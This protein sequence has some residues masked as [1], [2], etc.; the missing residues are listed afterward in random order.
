LTEGAGCHNAQQWKEPVRGRDKDWH[1]TSYREALNRPRFAQK[2]TSM[3]QESRQKAHERHPYH[4]FRAPAKAAGDGSGSRNQENPPIR[5]YIFER[6]GNVPPANRKANRQKKRLQWRDNTLMNQEVLWR[7]GVSVGGDY[8]ILSAWGNGISGRIYGE[9]LHISRFVVLELYIPATCWRTSIK[10]TMGDFE[11]LF[12]SPSLEGFLIGGRKDV[13]IN[14]L[15][16]MLILDKHGPT[17]SVDVEEGDHLPTTEITSDDDQDK[18]STAT[19][20]GDGSEAGNDSE[21][22]TEPDTL[23]MSPRQCD[24]L[25]I[26]EQRRQGLVEKLR[27]RRLARFK[28]QEL[29][30]N[31]PK[32]RR[33]AVVRKGMRVSGFCVVGSVFEFPT[34]PNYLL[35]MV[36][37]PMTSVTY[38]LPVGAREAGKILNMSLPPMPKWSI[39]VKREVCL[40]LLCSVTFRRADNDP[41][42]MALHLHGRYGIPDVAIDR[43]KATTIAA[44]ASSL[45]N[46]NGTYAAPKSGTSQK[47]RTKT[48]KRHADWSW[49]NLV[50]QGV[51]RLSDGSLGHFRCYT[52]SSQSFV[53]VHSPPLL[54]PSS[55]PL[56]CCSLFMER[57][58]KEKGL[59][60]QA[61]QG[62]GLDEVAKKEWARHHLG[63][64]FVLQFYLPSGRDQHSI[65]LRL[66]DFDAL[67]KKE[68]GMPAYLVD[69]CAPTSDAVLAHTHL[70]ET[71][72]EAIKL[73]L[74]ELQHTHHSLR[75]KV[76][77]R[78]TH[79]ERV[80]ADAREDRIV[81]DRQWSIREKQWAQQK[82]YLKAGKEDWSKKKMIEHEEIRF[83][84]DKREWMVVQQQLLQKE[85]DILITKERDNELLHEAEE[86]VEMAAS[87]L[88]AVEVNMEKRLTRIRNKALKAWDVIA[89]FTLNR[90]ISWKLQPSI[91]R[92]EFTVKLDRVRCDMEEI[93]ANLEEVNS[94][95]DDV[96]AKA[97]AKASSNYEA[98]EDLCEK[99]RQL[100]ELLT[101]QPPRKIG[102][103]LDRR[104]HEKC[105]TIE[106]ITENYP[107]RLMWVT[108]H[109]DA[110]QMIFVCH[111]PGTC[112]SFKASP[113]Q[114]TSTEMVLEFWNLKHVERCAVLDAYIMAIVITE[115]Y[116]TGEISAV[117][118]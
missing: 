104:I 97:G 65:S 103:S 61:L 12:A 90:K 72:I 54:N 86:C 11:T 106:S 5:K 13:L 52:F 77:K 27:L 22:A 46:N 94:N 102:L 91:H 36:Y 76:R 113:D 84:R 56:S 18:P 108:V 20:V 16:K 60:E 67:L 80:I 114:S 41:S 3:I 62:H 73:D 89:R 59:V 69:A 109:Q 111:E 29:W 49:H 70:E 116:E 1:L 9:G 33:G 75:R 92:H 78:T 55:S 107:S 95:D 44:R 4:M 64:E 93:K 110:L 31:T 37:S 115:D 6:W 24:R 23:R 21:Q 39:D 45:L 87:E 2:I 81:R 100:M 79:G 25:S 71:K 30:Q 35:V 8:C 68:A 63:T 53:C 42:E 112:T 40:K 85:Q 118:G 47:F 48:R 66:S 74:K 83:D 43:T 50:S 99:E 14:T 32:H 51:S 38:E 15:A 101:P 82:L 96:A 7:H 117:M 26:A 34:R 19:P 17:L 10:V 57:E 105:V 98:L 88:Y 28:A 58:K